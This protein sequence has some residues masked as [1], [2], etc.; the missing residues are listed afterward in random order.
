MPDA[1][2]ITVGAIPRD[3]PGSNGRDVGQPQGVAPTGN[4]LLLPD[5]IQR[6]EI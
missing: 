6:I 2:Q 4:A 5:A 3:C 1:A